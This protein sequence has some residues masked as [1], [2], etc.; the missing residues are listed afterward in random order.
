MKKFLKISAWIL[1]GLLIIIAGVLYWA[2][3]DVD[4]TPWIDS[5]YYTHTKA[6]LDSL[7]DQLTLAQGEVQIGFSK[8]SITPR[9]NAQKDDPYEG[10]FKALPLAGFGERKGRPAEGIHDSVFVKAVAVKVNDKMVV[11]VGSD[12]LIV[13]PSISEGVVKNLQEKMHISRDQIF[14]SATHTHSSAGAWSEG[15][16]GEEFAGKPNP[17]VVYWLVLRFSQAIEKAVRDLQPGAIG[18]GR[19]DAAAFINNRLIGKLGQKDTEFVFMVGRQNSGRTVVLGSFDAH[20]TTLGG[21]NM[22]ISADYPGY[23]ERKLENSGF[24]LAVFYAG[25]VGSHSPASKGKEFEKPRYIGEALADSVSK[26]SAMVQLKSNI[27]LAYLTLKLDLPEFHVRV[28]DGIRLNPYLA[29][30]LFPPVGEVCVQAARVD[31]LIW[32]TAPADFS[33]ETAIL[34]KNAM[35]RKGY[36]AIVTS[37]NGAYVGYVLPMRYYHMDEYETRLMSWFGPYM[38]PY[39]NEMIRRMMTSLADLKQGIDI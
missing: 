17:D 19:F 1:V 27:G 20:S 4:Y 33:G 6:R 32:A 31:G 29:A 13:P 37:F 15:Y 8:V 24:D 39:M 7:T 34:Y 25:S 36:K 26:Y 23:W 22:Y 10:A 14:F 5:A 38:G 21:W 16:V 18:S 35:Y 9:L 2:L 3:D 11:F 30:K 12:L 28:S